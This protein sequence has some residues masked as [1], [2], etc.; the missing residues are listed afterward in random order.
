MTDNKHLTPTAIVY[1]DGKRMDTEHEGALKEIFIKDVLNDISS[2]SLLFNNAH[3]K[4]ADKDL[5]ALE[6]EISI[7]LGYKD[8]VDEV[9]S[10]D[11][12]ELKALCHEYG[13]EQYE[14]SGY[15]VLHRL[16][17]GE[18][19]ES[20]EQMSSSD[21][22]KKMIDYFSLKA[23]VEDFG[24]VSDFST[25]D[26]LTA[27]DYLT[28]TA[29]FYGK[30][31]FAD[32]DTI[33]IAN[34]I[35]IRNDE[36]IL[37][38]GKSLISFQENLNVKQLV[39]GYDYTG[40]DTLKGESF[41]GS[42][43]MADLPVKV[44]GDSDWTKVYKGG[45]DSKFRTQLSDMGLTDA[46]DA[47]QRAI[48]MLQKN[49]FWFSKARGKCEGNYKIR[50][51]MRVTIKMAGE[52]HDKEFIVE[53]VIHKFSYDEGYTTTV[54]LKR[55]MI[56]G[57]TTRTPSEM[58]KQQATEAN[59]IHK[60]QSVFGSDS[61]NTTSTTTEEDSK[62]EEA[63]KNPVLNNPKWLKDGNE[64]TESLVDDEVVLSVEVRDIDDRETVQLEIWENDEDNDH[65]FIEKLQGKVKDGKAEVSWK[66]K[67][68]ADD[69]D[70]TSGKE[71]AEKGYTLPEYHFAA[72][73]SSSETSVSE[74]L[75]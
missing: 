54:G 45:N 20:Y 66:V 68:T 5:F 26:G 67:Y 64:I 11:V 8:D 48:G 61:V 60:E 22:I 34:E 43:S 9:F 25:S 52:E 47:K 19:C 46:T 44:G 49:S 15:N 59:T 75:P 21:I 73:Y 50:P 41:T 33:Y 6:S 23:K 1:V 17:H 2:F 16:K 55:N 13:T 70:S 32:K 12:L 56:S 28:H 36:I 27:Y 58:D 38:W 71:L 35:T 69:D 29:N 3:T 10:G 37:E 31:V 24:A 74:E 62:N 7:H 14:V 40:W 72:H 39:S 4:I 63:Q 30:E 51:G 42:A 65:D 53:E 57:I 18:H